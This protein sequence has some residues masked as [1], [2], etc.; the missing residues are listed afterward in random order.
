MSRVFLVVGMIMLAAPLLAMG[1][2]PA[3]LGPSIR[4][5]APPR[6]VVL[7]VV[8]Q[9]S[10]DLFERY[11]DLFKGGFRKLLDGGRVY[12][13][14]TFDY[15]VTETS[16]GHA[17]M[18][19]GVYPARHGV[20]ANAWWEQDDNLKWNR[21]VNVL[22]RESPLIELPRYAGASPRVLL[23]PGLADW[24]YQQDDDTKVVSIAGKE[25]AAILMASLNRGQVYWFDAL[26][27]R[28]VT[29]V[30]YRDKYPRWVRRFNKG[31]ITEYQS[32]ST[33]WSEIPE[34]AL[35][36][37]RPDTTVYEADGTN[38]AFPH[39]F[40][41]GPVRDPPLDFNEW[42]ATTPAVDALVLEMARAAVD[43]EDLGD[44]DTPDLLAVSLSQTD[45]IGHAF[46]P[47]SREQ[48]DNLLR[49]D[50]ELGE[51]FE[52]LDAEIGQEAYVVA[53]AADH[54]VLEIPEFIQDGDRPGVRLTRDALGELQAR[55]DKVVRENAG[56]GL[57]A[58]ANAL[59]KVVSDL[60]WV[61]RAWTDEDLLSGEL[62]D[63][64][65]VYMR[66]S[67]YPG[68]RGGLLS[69]FGVEMLLQPN[70]LRWDFPRGTTHGTPYLYDRRVPFILMGPGIE[71]GIDENRVSPMDVAPTLADFAQVAYPDDLDGTSRRQ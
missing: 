54:G 17:T 46:G 66:R 35:A 15:A 42:L 2:R 21:V 53:F 63:S 34:L 10:A 12:P 14:A 68:R 39:V 5:E 33:W 69:R 20:V 31:M 38:T 19:T 62:T 4:Q 65:S 28:F 16:P 11:Q 51:F 23:R 6:L 40:R 7:L 60:P 59:V 52:Y 29:S 3:P 55:F 58:I 18:A 64:M 32:D 50:R 49:L 13:N 30:Y 8:D 61:A 26:L 24:M 22:D 47:Y 44:D 27:G 56:Q 70:H 57:N 36:R 67:L 9:L 48:L 45:K 71:A 43:A 25:R 41:E 1:P 37:S